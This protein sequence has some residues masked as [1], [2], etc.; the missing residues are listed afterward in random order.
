MNTKKLEN[1]LISKKEIILF[2]FIS[3]IFSVII[4]FIEFLSYG[5][6]SS[7]QCLN[8]FLFCFSP[9]LCALVINF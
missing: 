6:S 3:F 4:F 5:L 8:F 1:Y 7:A 9:V 2:F